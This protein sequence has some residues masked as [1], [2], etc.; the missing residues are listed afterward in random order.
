MM[1]AQGDALAGGP[2]HK[3]HTRTKPARGQVAVQ[4]SAD[5]SAA[6]K[7]A[8]DFTTDLFDPAVPEGSDAE[9]VR[10][11]Q[12]KAKAKEDPEVKMLK[13]KA[14]EAT[15]GEEVRRTSLAYNQTLFRKMKQIDRS[16]AE[17]VDLVEAAI[18]KKIKD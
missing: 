5:G 10:Y 14:D 11:E 2:R 18:V 8:A 6:Q 12:A 15:G 3:Q 1:L 7:A 17:R 9:D 16:I 13:A 4:D